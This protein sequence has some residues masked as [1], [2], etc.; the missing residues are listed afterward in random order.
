[1]TVPS[2]PIALLVLCVLSLKTW[3]QSV[4]SSGIPV[5]LSKRTPHSRNHTEWGIWAKTQHAAVLQKY[6][7]GKAEL[8]ERNNEAIAY[9]ATLSIGT[10]PVSFDVLLDTGS[11]NLWVAGT[12]CGSPCSQITVFDDASSS[13]FESSHMDF[14]V[15][16]G[17]GAVSGSFGQ[18][19]V[20]MG[21][22]TLPDQMFGVVDQIPSASLLGNPP[23]LSGF[24]GLGWQYLANGGVMP[25]WQALVSGGM[26][27][28][29]VMSFQLTRRF[30]NGSE[31]QSVEPGGTFTMGFI[32][33]TA[34]IGNI[35]YQNIT[36]ESWWLLPI[37]VI[38]VQ[39]LPMTMPPGSDS[40][41]AI[42]TGTTN[43]LGP[44]SAIQAIY[45]QIS[46]S[47][48]ATGDWEGYYT[49]PCSTEV[50]IAL[51]FG[52]PNWTI[53]SADFKLTELSSGSCIGAFAGFG[54][55]GGMDTPAWIVGDTFL[56]NVYSIF[57]YDPPSVGFAALS[58][59]A[60]AA[61]NQ[62]GKSSTALGWV[63]L[64]PS[65]LTWGVVPAVL[66]LLVWL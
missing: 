4:P 19:V 20:Q 15:S 5:P 38:T 6:T 50:N 35:D 33:D 2:I 13:T 59:S 63:A 34:Y 37:T 56:K 30:V 41:A 39:D 3:S 12:S 47:E 14:G 23:T 43:I 31:T 9:F 61:T 10:P 32:D 60:L 55:N 51:S 22:F 58:E 17:D 49:Y 18:D 24:L 1:M 66:S 52:G 44:D 46:G 42:D 16:Y 8:L 27:D 57:R 25:F 29:P 21:G 48:P 7:G 36:A 26:W 53:S 65:R 62:D 45:A 64:L 54:S 11:S 40:Y 28:S